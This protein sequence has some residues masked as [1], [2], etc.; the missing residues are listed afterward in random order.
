MNATHSWS[1]ARSL[2]FI[3]LSTGCDESTASFYLAAEGDAIDAVHAFKADAF[4]PAVFTCMD[5][6]FAC[7]SGVSL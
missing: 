4:A 6:E 2:T 3:M 1:E 7:Y 5:G